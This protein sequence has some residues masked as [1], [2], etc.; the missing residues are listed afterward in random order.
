MSPKNKGKFGKGKPAI[1]PQ[2]EFVSGVQKAAERLR[3]HARIIFTFLGVVLLGVAGWTLY[4][5]LAFKKQVKAS[6]HY[7]E[8]VAT[9]R[10]KVDPPP[11]VEAGQDAGVEEPAPPDDVELGSKEVTYASEEDRDRAMM[12][13]LD[14]ISG[15]ARVSHQARLL[16]GAAL[17]RVGEYDQAIDVYR[18]YDGPADL[19]WMAR[20]GIGYALEA[21]AAAEKDSAAREAGMRA[22]LDQFEQVQP[23]TGKPGHDLGLWHEG[24]LQAALQQNAE[25]IAAF[26]KLR[27]LTPAS[28]LK[29]NAE[30]RIALL[31]AKKVAAKTPPPAAPD[32]PAVPPAAHP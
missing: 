7:V 1:E 2:D 24:R 3:P 4:K 15:S 27:D 25:A 9:A 31:Q 26:E 6:R 22:A 8:A 20:E 14:E 5:H 11:P 32:K 28:P 17:L 29:A 12:A 23:E 10:R 21:K 13:A 19:A 30:A 18:S 16:K